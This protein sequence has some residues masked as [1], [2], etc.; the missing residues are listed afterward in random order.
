MR[1]TKRTCTRVAWLVLLAGCYH[2]LI[3]LEK[4]KKTKI[5]QAN[6]KQQRQK[7]N[8]PRKQTPKNPGCSS[9]QVAL[10]FP[11]PGLVSKHTVYSWPLFWLEGLFLVHA[12]GVSIWQHQFQ[13]LFFFFPGEHFS[14]ANAF[15]GLPGTL[16][17]KWRSKRPFWIL[18][19]Y[20]AQTKEESTFVYSSSF[21]SEETCLARSA[22]CSWGFKELGFALFLP[23]S[24]LL[25]ERKVWG[26]KA[27]I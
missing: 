22:H 26:Q 9:G 24:W 23:Q 21:S 11:L 6:P 14:S 10:A 15:C 19:A 27:W 25:F 16:R 12:L 18:M 2:E 1:H 17:A 7:Q 20:P 4:N 8:H 13:S 5:N 3:N